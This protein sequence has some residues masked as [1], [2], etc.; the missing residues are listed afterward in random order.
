[1]LK[2]PTQDLRYVA[3]DETSPGLSA[4]WTALTLRSADHAPCAAPELVLPFLGH[5]NIASVYAQDQLVLAM[6]LERGRLFDRSYDSPISNCGLCHADRLNG[7]AALLLLLCKSDRPIL[8]RSV[9][10]Q[11]QFFAMLEG[12]AGHFSVLQSWQ[13]AGLDVSGSFADWQARSLV[14]KRRKEL[15]RLRNR[16]SQQGDVK[17]ETL[18]KNADAEPFISEFLT[19]ESAGW[20]GERGTALA[21]KAGLAAATQ[22]AL[23]GLHRAGKLRFWSLKL[24]A[25]TIATLFAYVEGNK[26]CLGK[27]AYDQS[28]GKYS[29]GSLLVLDATESIFNEGIMAEVDSSAIPGH[30]MI[31]HLWR[32]RIG[33]ADVM[34]APATVSTLRFATIMWSEKLRRTFRAVLKSIYYR[35]TG[36]SQS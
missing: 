14:Q 15:R 28:F 8:L 13:R 11:S 1:M 30:P 18:E 25:R 17:L 12:A 19:L 36:K 29:P 4:A 35:L 16:L 24:G 10:V 20:K 22:A 33:F 34:V 21:S 2:Q 27:V 31:D 23:G 3:N 6:P 9:P 26:A 32:N 7:P 5:A